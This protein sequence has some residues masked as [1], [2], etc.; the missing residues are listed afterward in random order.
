MGKRTKRKSAKEVPSPPTAKRRGF[1]LDAEG[2][3]SLWWKRGGGREKGRRGEEG[4]TIHL[5][6]V[7]AVPFLGGG[8]TRLRGRMLK[9]LF[10]LHEFSAALLL[11]RKRG[12]TE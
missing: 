2:V 4:N 7:S 11:K 6:P 9:R 10:L 5:F 3:F 1:G 12:L 8:K